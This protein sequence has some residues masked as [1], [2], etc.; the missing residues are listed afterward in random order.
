MLARLE[1]PRIPCAS[2]T[3]RGDRVSGAP[4]CPDPSPD[5]ASSKPRDV[6][7]PL[8]LSSAR[9]SSS[10]P[11]SSFPSAGNSIRAPPI[12]LSVAALSLH[13]VSYTHLRAHE[14]EAD[15]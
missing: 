2:R 11:V 3:E 7:P 4:G 5:P 9:T 14:T 8:M 6:R 10:K 13:T 15:L 12:R 1:K